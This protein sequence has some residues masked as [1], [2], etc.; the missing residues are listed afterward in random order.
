MN[1]WTGGAV[2][3][4]SCVTLGACHI[5]FF[6][7]KAPT[8]QVVATVGSREITQ[9]ELQMAMGN[10]S[11]GDPK[12]RKARE[13]AV[14][15]NLVTGIVLANAARDQGLDKTPEF[16]IQKSHVMDQLL[17][18]S[19]QKKIVDQV[20]SVTKDEAQAFVG[21]HPDIFAERKIFVVDQIRMPRLDP[22]MLKALEPLKTL[23]AIEGVLKANNVPYQRAPASLDSVGADPRLVD[24]IVKLPAGEVFVIPSGNGLTVNQIKDTKVQPFTGDPAVDY[25]QKLITRQRTQDSLTNSFRQL[26]AKAKPTVRFNKDYAPPPQSNSAH[27]LPKP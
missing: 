27:P 25:A 24:Q 12:A 4:I 19:L 8:G 18:Q 21:A 13:Q 1:K 20:P 16:A 15:N 9:R 11:G 2:V 22:G 14:L 6:G 10:A 5:P 26:M 7:Q 3:A 23:E 17:I